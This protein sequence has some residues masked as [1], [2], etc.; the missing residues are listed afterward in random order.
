MYHETEPHV[1]T[2]MD[3]ERLKRLWERL[4]AQGA[5]LALEDMS[6]PALAAEVMRRHDAL[7]DRLKGV[8]E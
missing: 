4:E 5:E 3:P 1:N 2:E 6:I 7:V 8:K